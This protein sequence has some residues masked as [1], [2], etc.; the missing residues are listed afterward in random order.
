MLAQTIAHYRIQAKIGA[1]GMGEVYRATDTRLS[2]DVAIK[3]LP[4]AFARDGDRMARFEREAKVLASLNHPNIASI[5]GLEESNGARA[6]I[7]ELVEGPT[8][9][10]RIKQGRLSL[11]EA[12]PIVKQI[13]DALE[14]AHERGI[15]HRDLKP[16][17]VKLTLDGQVKVLDFGLA[18]ALEGE[19]SEEELQ[20]SPTLSAVAT[21]AGMLLGTAAYMSPEQARGKRVDRRADIWAFGCVLYEMLTGRGAFSGETTS[22]ILACVIRAEP[23]WSS[24]PAHVPTRIRELLRVCL[25]K[26]PKQRLQAIGDARI[27]LE[28]V[29]SGTPQEAGAPPAQTAE[30]PVWLRALP[31]AAGVLLALVVGVAVW[32]LRPRSDP[33][34]VVEFSFGPPTGDTLAFPGASMPLAI[35]PDGTAVVF[36][37]RHAGISQLYLRRVD[38]LE[39]TPLKGTDDALYP[40]FSPNGQWVAFF[41]AGKLKKVSVLGGTPVTLC[42][43]PASR[44]GTWAPDDFIILAPSSTSGLMRVSAAG[45]TPEPFTKLDSSK[46][47]GS[48]RWPQV[49]PGGK[50]VLFNAGDFAGQKLII[51]I[52][53]TIS[54]A[55]LKTGEVRT[56]PLQGSNVRYLPGYLVFTRGET[57]FAAPFDVQRLEVTGPAFPAGE[58]LISPIGSASFA[59]SETGSLVYVAAGANIGKLAWVDAKGLR[60]MPGLPARNYSNR[61]QL[62]PD[63]KRVV[64]V[65]LEGGLRHIWVYDTVRGS[66]T[67]LTFGDSDN[68]SPIWSPDGRRIAFA[69][70]K[71]GDWA[72]LTKPADGSGS[73]ETLLSAGAGAPSSWSPDGRFLACF[74]VGPTWKWEIWVLPLEGERKSQPL[75]TNNQFDQTNAVFSPDGKY[76]AYTSNESGRYEVYVRPFGQGSSKWQ[77]STGGGMFPVWARSGKQLFYRESGNIMAVDVTTQPAFSVSTPRVMVPSAVTAPLSNGIDSFDVSLDGQHFLVHQQSSEAGQSVQINVILSWSEELRRLARAN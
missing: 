7:M 2:R 10:E 34:R 72:V 37:A 66:L 20:N 45:G 5:Y 21:R 56:L 9:A 40:F 43:A 24:L 48:H 44:G 11:D 52:N 70:R 46:G 53:P 35:S 36:T 1:G 29:L 13:A 64:L 75:L 73:E 6:L 50:A 17:N 58:V 76:V 55:A 77:I 30:R 54:L 26:D 71:G 47:E 14:Y 19:T 3:V 41:A 68:V 27:A 59:V 61:L 62:S 60:E 16:P 12:L 42:E 38:R 63:G 67:R 15:I 25:Q 57:L 22:D 23:D 74:Q 31:W 51:T 8:L 39:A 28:E 69:S 33:R 32:E 49:L 65:I 4:Q 18:K